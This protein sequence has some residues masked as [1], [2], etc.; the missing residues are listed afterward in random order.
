MVV[1]GYEGAETNRT[2]CDDIDGALGMGHEISVSS[3]ER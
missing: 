3:V 2:F 1:W